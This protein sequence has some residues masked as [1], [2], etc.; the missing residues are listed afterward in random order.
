MIEVTNFLKVLDVDVA[1]LMKFYFMC[2]NVLEL[3]LLLLRKI[4]RSI[5]NNFFD[6]KYMYINMVLCVGDNCLGT[7]RDFLSSRVSQRE[8][9]QKVSVLRKTCVQ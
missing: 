9:T 6:K 4:I 7:S 5:L 8:E 1:R 2:N 3:F